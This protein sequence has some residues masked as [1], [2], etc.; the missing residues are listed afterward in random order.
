MEYVNLGRS[1]LKVSKIILGCMSYGEKDWDEW[2]LE[3]PESLEMLHH[4]YQRGINTWDTADVYSYGRS[5]EIVGKALE[6][7]NIPRERVVIMSKCYFGAEK[8]P[9]GSAMGRTNDGEFVN[10][11]G[12][13]RKHILDSVEGSVKRLGT[14]LDVLWIHRLDRETPK[15]EIMR[16]LNDVIERGWVRY[17]GASSMAAWEF[18]QLQNIAE[19]HG[20]HKFVAMQNLYNLLYREEER[21]M[22]PYCQNTGV[23]LTPW[24]ALAS[25]TL[26]RPWKGS[27]TERSTHDKFRQGV[28]GKGEEA[29]KVIVD[30]VEEIAKKKGVAMAQVTIA[31]LLSKKYVTPILGLS[32]TSRIDEAVDAVKVK[33]TDEEISY[34]EEPY[35]PK[36]VTGY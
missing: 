29:D 7:Y 24:Y 27:S 35:Q 15:E 4:A 17:I 32:K 34:L 28:L 13:S 3:E 1:G 6:K 33:L 8:G 16:A 12:L 20:W 19:K 10:R 26:A 18:Q 22:I 5:E 23:G 11:M 25:G 30:R 2:V 21:E 9:I 31:W 36:R 14:Y